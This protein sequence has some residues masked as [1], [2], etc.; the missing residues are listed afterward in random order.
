M[1]TRRSRA[2]VSAIIIGGFSGMVSIARPARA[3]VC[4]D[5]CPGLPNPCVVAATVNV[6]PGSVIDCG[7]L[8]V[9][10]TGGNLRVT[11]GQFTLRAGSVSVSNSK[12]IES[13]CSGGATQH[14]F[15]IETWGTITSSGNGGFKAT[16]TTGGGSVSMLAVGSVTLGGTGIDASGT[17]ATGRGGV[18]R[19]LSFGNVTTTAA[20]KANAVT[21]TGTG[22]AGGG[23]DI[24]AVSISIDGDLTASGY[25]RNRGQG[26]RLRASDDIIIT[27]GIVNA[28]TAS[29][30]GGLITLLA[31]DTID[32]RR[33]LKVEGVGADA[34]GGVITLEADVVKVTRDLVAHGGDLGGTVAIEARKRLDVG[35]GATQSFDLDVDRS[36]SNPGEG[37][38]LILTSEGHDVYIG[39][40]VNLKASATGGGQ[41]GSID[42]AGV[43]VTA[44]SGSKIF[45][46]GA[47][48]Q[49][50]TIT[51]E[52]REQMS[53]FGTLHATNGESTFS[54]REGGPSPIVGAGVTGVWSTEADDSL[55]PS[56]GDGI[57]YDPAEQCDDP[58]LGGHT[59][60]TATCTSCD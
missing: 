3:T 12:K 40:L 35:L 34:S 22:V 32:V 38:E 55:D 9:Q 49:G 5:I 36:S 15:R 2:A 11:N 50:G 19:I 58:D 4:S 13:L 59:C 23:I 30:D 33:P 16:C 39:P 44:A 21:T 57:L 1:M 8:P 14:G 18:V 31:A 53:L 47:A 27:G 52:A 45:A 10:V 56:C 17:T 26:I 43:A 41:G 29:G 20:I 28:G 51:I 7:V 54:Y 42:I 24:R 6:T 25:K 46:D 48:D 60:C 37:G